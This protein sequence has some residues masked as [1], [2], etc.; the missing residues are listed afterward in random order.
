M[1]TS[2]PSIEHV[3][4]LMIGIAGC[5]SYTSSD[6]TPQ[7]ESSHQALSAPQD[8]QRGAAPPAGQK[9][10]VGLQELGP[11]TMPPARTPMNAAT[12]KAS[13]GD[14]DVISKLRASGLAMAS[15]AGVVSPNKISCRRG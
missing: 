8:K 9:P 10:P 4:A 7:T 13:L 1:S 15:I 14:S 6:Q 5:A 12:L 2:K 3:V 11:L